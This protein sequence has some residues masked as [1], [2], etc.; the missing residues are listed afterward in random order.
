MFR[1]LIAAIAAVAINATLDV[2][3]DTPML[4]RGIIAVVAAGF[5]GQ[6]VARFTRTDRKSGRD[7]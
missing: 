4:L 5:I 6:L 7:E 3:F 1:V 2:V